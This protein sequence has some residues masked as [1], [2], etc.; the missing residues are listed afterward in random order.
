MFFI[1]CCDSP[2]LWQTY[3]ADPAS[4]SMEGILM[5]N[6]HLLFLL[7]VIVL[8]VGWL[9]VYTIFYFIEYNNNVSSA[10]VHS[11]ASI[12]F[13]IFSILYMDFQEWERLSLE[14][15]AAFRKN[16]PCYFGPCI[17]IVYDLE[18]GLDWDTAEAWITDRHLSNGVLVVNKWQDLDY[19][20]CWGKFGTPGNL[21]NLAFEAITLRPKPRTYTAKFAREHSLRMIQCHK[22]PIRHQNG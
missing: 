12:F 3:L 14:A 10:F 20:Q 16:H 15:E 6:K 19:N 18:K 17:E 5:F 7:T 2:A 9:L 22:V 21:R 1:T 13:H 11:K 4:I 8:L